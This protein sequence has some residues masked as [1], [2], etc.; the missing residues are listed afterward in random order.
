MLAEFK[1][2]FRFNQNTR[3]TDIMRYTVETDPFPYGFH[4]YTQGDPLV[5]EHLGRSEVTDRLE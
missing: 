3:Y 4:L 1:S 2:S 5:S